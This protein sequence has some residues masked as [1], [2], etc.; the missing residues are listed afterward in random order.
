MCET[1]HAARDEEL[2]RVLRGILASKAE[3]PF[4]HLGRDNLA[5]ANCGLAAR[6]NRPVF[7][8][9]G[10]VFCTS[11]CAEQSGWGDKLTRKSPPAPTEP[12]GLIRLLAETVFARI[13]SAS[14]FG[15]PPR[16]QTIDND[17]EASCSGILSAYQPSGSFS[18]ELLS[19]SDHGD[20]ETR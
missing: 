17:S 18:A 6:P 5:C 16:P 7:V 12:K 19:E 4:A 1:V 10:E 20:K 2:D 11:D 9:Q 14:G 13:R 8:Q 15:P 3:E